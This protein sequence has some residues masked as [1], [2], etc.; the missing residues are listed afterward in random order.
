MRGTRYWLY[1]PPLSPL[2]VFRTPRPLRARLKNAKKCI[3]EKIVNDGSTSSEVYKNECSVHAT[4]I[5]RFRTTN[6]RKLGKR[7]KRDAFTP[8]LNFLFS[9]FVSRATVSS[10]LYRVLL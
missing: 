2:R 6:K 4:I 1:F 8:G 5:L 9:I 7:S 10:A 3:N